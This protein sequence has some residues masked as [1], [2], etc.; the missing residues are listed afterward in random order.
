MPR[1]GIILSKFV[2]NRDSEFDPCNVPFFVYSVHR[3]LVAHMQVSRRGVV[4][5][6][7]RHRHIDRELLSV[8]VSLGATVDWSLNVSACTLAAGW[9]SGIE[10]R[11]LCRWVIGPAALGG[12]L[13]GDGSGVVTGGFVPVC[14]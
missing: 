8:T 6:G 14:G 12:E 7:I 4:I 3:I 2:E 11:W 10:G 9:T 13:C 5:G 1:Y